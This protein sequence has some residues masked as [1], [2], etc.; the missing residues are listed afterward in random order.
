MDGQREKKDP[1]EVVAAAIAALGEETAASIAAHAGMAYSTVTPKLRALEAAGRAQKFRRDGQTLWRLTP[2]ATASDP[3]QPDDG[4]GRDDLSD[5]ASQQA[6]D[7]D[8]DPGNAKAAATPSATSPLPPA[9]PTTPPVSGSVATATPDPATEPAT[10]PTEPFGRPDPDPAPAG[11][12]TRRPPGQLGRTALQILR[13]SPQTVYKVG[14]MAKL[15]NK[16]DEG[17]GYPAASP[18]AVVLAL[19]KLVDQGQARQVTEQPASYQSANQA[20]AEA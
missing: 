3:D 7:P 20:T 8:Q 13:Q 14:E 15:I 9:T 11:G 17:N 1:V 12:G 10:E 18:G 19:N 4:G 16:A 2:Q 5:S 6:T